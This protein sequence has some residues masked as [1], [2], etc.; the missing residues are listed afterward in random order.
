M[1]TVII[2]TDKDGFGFNVSSG[3]LWMSSSK[4][5]NRY[6]PDCDIP[7]SEQ[8]GDFI[9]FFGYAWPIGTY[10]RG[11]YSYDVFKNTCF[12]PEYSNVFKKICGDM[13]VMKNGWPKLSDMKEVDEQLMIRFLTANREC[14]P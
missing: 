9:Y 3:V 13:D 10:I 12:G 5:G 1:K 7:C 8:R 6:H 14:Q 4:N 11:V 2:N